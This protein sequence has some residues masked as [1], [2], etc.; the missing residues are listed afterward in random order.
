[1]NAEIEKAIA[2][3]AG[4]IKEGVTTDEAMKLAQAVL[5]IANARVALSHA[6]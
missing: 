1:M 3:L 6:K 4:K 5:N 2:F